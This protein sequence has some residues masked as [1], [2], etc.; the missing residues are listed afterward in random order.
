MADHTPEQRL[1]RRVNLIMM[2]LTAVG[3]AGAGIYWGVAGAL[4]FLAGAA[5]S[6][7]NFRWLSA[8]VFALGTIDPETQRPLKPA[9]AMLLGARYLVFAAVGYGIFK[10]SETG[11]L[12]ALAGCFVHIGAVLLEIF[13]ELIYGTS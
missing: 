12:A 4:G 9:P 2:G 5:V 6:F 8:V 11:F 13:Y 3:V 10:Y 7:L 1:V